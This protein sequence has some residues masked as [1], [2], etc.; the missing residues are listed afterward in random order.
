MHTC[1]NQSSKLSLRSNALLSPFI[2]ANSAGT[3]WKEEP[4]GRVGPQRQCTPSAGVGNPQAQGW[5]ARAG[6]Q[7]PSCELQTAHAYTPASLPPADRNTHA[8]H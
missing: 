7:Q 8:T 5:D 2:A 4:A 3:L 6:M 1:C